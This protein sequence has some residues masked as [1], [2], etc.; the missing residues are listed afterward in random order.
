MLNLDPSVSASEVAE[1]TGL[2]SGQLTDFSQTSFLTT[3]S[4]YV[5]GVGNQQVVP[6]LYLEEAVP[7]HPPVLWVL[8]HGRTRVPSRTS[9]HSRLLGRWQS[10]PTCEHRASAGA[11]GSYTCPLH[12]YPR[13]MRPSCRAGMTCGEKLTQRAGE[14]RASMLHLRETVVPS[15]PRQ[16]IRLPPY[17]KVPFGSTSWPHKLDPDIVLP[18]AGSQDGGL[19]L[20]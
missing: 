1:I 7:D 8:T 14:G 11:P 2:L 3:L 9:Q 6:C 4:S 18:K 16:P 10:W 20:F 13:R 5:T 15:N 17:S 19:F 12:S